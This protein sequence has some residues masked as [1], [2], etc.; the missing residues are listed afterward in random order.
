M[1]ASWSNSK[2]TWRAYLCGAEM[3]VGDLIYDSAFDMN[4][5]VIEVKEDSSYMTVLYDDGELGTGVRKNDPE[6]EVIDESR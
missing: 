1:A 3:K 4:G 6:I 5:L 2:G